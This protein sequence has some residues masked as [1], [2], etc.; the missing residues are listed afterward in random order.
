MNTEVINLYQGLKL[1]FIKSIC[2][3]ISTMVVVLTFTSPV[4]AHH[5][6]WHKMDPSKEALVKSGKKIYM[7]NC[8]VCHGKNLEGQA[9]WRQR[10]PDGTLP[11]PPQDETGHTWH[12]G[13]EM[14]FGVVKNGGPSNANHKS[15]MPP[16]KGVL[17]DQDIWD[18]LTFIKSRWPQHVQNRHDMISEKSHRYM[19]DRHMKNMKTNHGH[20][21]KN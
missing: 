7:K 20:K 13:S 14:L 4:L 3:F 8:A 9:N 10:N 12:H 1:M 6:P 16:F 11:A 21:H 2:F 5:K 17:S 18:V 15:M 19:Q